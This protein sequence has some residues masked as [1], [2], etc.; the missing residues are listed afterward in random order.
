MTLQTPHKLEPD[1][2]ALDQKGRAFRLRVNR[3]IL[4]TL[5]ISVLL[6]LL[7]LWLFAPKFFSIGAPQ[8][9]VRPLEISLGPPQEKQ[10]ASG[11]LVLPDLRPLP[12]PLEKSKSQ[13]PKLA[14]KAKPKEAKQKP[15]PVKTAE[16]SKTKITQTAKT[17]EKKPNP[18][19]KEKALV[20]LPGEDM[21]AFVRRQ[22]VARLGK[23]GLSELDIEEVL[24]SSRPRSEGDKRDA[25]IRK[26]LNQDGISGIFS[27]RALNVH[28]AQ[29]SFK[30]WRNNI[31]TARLEIIDVRAPNGVDIKLAVIR[32]MIEI[33]RR[34]YDGDFKWDSRRTNSVITLSARIEDTQGL[35]GFLMQEFFGPNG[36]YR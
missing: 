7:L 1:W 12:Q 2:S 25:R 19:P 16:V 31:N 3:D 9:N 28:T 35:E 13:K 15:P 11:E 29:F 24:A 20:P 5:V 21:Q 10:T 23:R 30:G 32:K 22:K 26:N 4:L 33:I 27:I 36:A 14:K 8:K 18:V 6:H 17:A 34:E